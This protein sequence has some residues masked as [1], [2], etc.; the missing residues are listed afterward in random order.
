MWRFEG[1]LPLGRAWMR[2]RTHGRLARFFRGRG[3]EPGP[4]VLDRSRVFVLPTRRGAAF[5]LVVTALFVGSINYGNSLGLLLTFWLG[6]L[7]FV[8][9]VHTYLDLA[10]LHLRAGRPEPVFA[11]E[12]ARFPLWLENPSGRPHR[13]L[14]LRAEAGGGGPEV[15]ADV[16]GEASIV[17][18]SR[19][20]E[21][22]GTLPLGRI[23]VRT[24]YPL[25]LVRAW[26]PAEPEVGCLVYPAP[27]PPYPLPAEMVTSGGE[28]GGGAGGT[29]D[30]GG[31]RTFLPG[32][33]PRSVHWRAS[34]R[35]DTLLTKLWSGGA[36]AVVWLAWDDVLEPDPEARLSR[37]CRW[38]LE[39]HGTG[40]TWGLRLPGAEVPA[41]AGE[42]HLHRC[43][44]TLAL[45]QP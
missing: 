34:A 32:D 30:F 26:A 11:G 20:A 10:H 6:S 23:T 12:W 37:L 21:R 45:W 5:A 28:V 14:R 13:A 35:M 2:A 27:G 19:R 1:V 39:A 7:A 16:V 41:A 9:I 3:P 18:L 44:E 33:A 42:A 43:L 36:P 24:R 31:L 15:S 22:R 8:S 38:I 40:L 4:V 25:G 29:D 17:I